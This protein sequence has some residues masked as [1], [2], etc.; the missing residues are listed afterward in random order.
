MF[1]FLI[2]AANA[3]NQW[4]GGA[5]NRWRNMAEYGGSCRGI[6]HQSLQMLF[7][8]QLATRDLVLIAVRVWCGLRITV[9]GLQQ[10]A[11]CVQ[12]VSLRQSFSQFNKSVRL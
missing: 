11:T 5:I 7:G 1:F 8:Y 6:V 2:V 4:R 3:S 10:V 9:S 12:A